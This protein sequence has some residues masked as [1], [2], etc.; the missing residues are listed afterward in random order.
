MNK[1]KVNFLV[2]F[3]SLCL[4]EYLTVVEGY[5]GLFIGTFAVIVIL[6]D[7][8]FNLKLLQR[9]S[10]LIDKLFGAIK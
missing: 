2:A 3:M 10:N 1:L 5:R 6:L 4:I 9:L 8:N 7:Y